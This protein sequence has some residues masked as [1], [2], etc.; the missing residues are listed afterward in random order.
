MTG[1]TV[2]LCACGLALDLWGVCDHC[3]ERVCCP[4]AFCTDVTTA[5]RRLDAY[6]DAEA[7]AEAHPRSV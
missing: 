5:I 1:G 3:D 4:C 6:I 7:E 2:R